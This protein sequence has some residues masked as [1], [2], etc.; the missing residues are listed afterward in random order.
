[1]PEILNAQASLPFPSLASIPSSRAP[2]RRFPF[3]NH[4]HPPNIAFWSK[5]RMLARSSFSSSSKPL[6]R[7]ISFSPSTHYPRDNSPRIRNRVG[8]C[9]YI[10][11]RISRNRS[12]LSL[13]ARIDAHTAMTVDLRGSSTIARYHFRFNFATLAAEL[14]GPTTTWGSHNS[15]Y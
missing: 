10:R 9:G 6:S 13:R 4:A 7:A 11:R 8:N 12:Q 3:T 14:D 15:A 1:M 5:P 2:H